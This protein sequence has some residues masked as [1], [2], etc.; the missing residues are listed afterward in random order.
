MSRKSLIWFAQLGKQ[1]ACRSLETLPAVG[2]FWRQLYIIQ[3][4]RLVAPFTSLEKV[5]NYS[6]RVIC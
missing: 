5:V 4:V 3:F 6:R 2:K 1:F